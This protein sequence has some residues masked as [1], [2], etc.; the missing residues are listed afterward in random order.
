M[1]GS[2]S[3]S[4]GSPG[5]SG[6]RKSPTKNDNPRSILGY[7]QRCMPRWLDKAALREQDPLPPLTRHR[8][9]LTSGRDNP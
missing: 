9:R 1:K 6:K 2:S 4:G 3:D 7:K 5:W 8:C